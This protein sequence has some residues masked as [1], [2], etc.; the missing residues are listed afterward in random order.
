M[1]RIFN[2]DSPVM[3]V[4][5]KIADLFWLNILTMLCCLPIITAGAALTAAH[6]VGLKMARNEENYI[7][8][9]FFKSFKLNFKQ[10]TPIWLLVLLIAAIFGMDYLIITRTSLQIPKVL[11]FII[12]MVAMLFLFMVM[13]VFPVQAKFDNKIPRTI[14]N[15]FS[16]SIAQL[17]RTILMVILYILPY[18][19]CLL[20]YRIMPLFF[21]FGISAPVYFSAKLYNKMFKR[22]EERIQEREAEA[23]DASADQEVED[24]DKIFSD[25]LLIEEDRKL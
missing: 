6:Y 16:L 23:A 5:N 24:P 21:V 14:R 4:L 10:A 9:D 20:S 2:L 3:Q 25:K 18:V 8:K 13:W 1:G 19:I 22:L 17:P 7:T 11:Q 12:L 15:A